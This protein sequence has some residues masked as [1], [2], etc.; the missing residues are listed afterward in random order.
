VVRQRLDRRPLVLRLPHLGFGIWACM[1]VAANTCS[2]RFYAPA[3]GP[4]QPAGFGMSKRVY[5][6]S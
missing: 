5:A 3:R 4:K 1:V 6:T 2:P